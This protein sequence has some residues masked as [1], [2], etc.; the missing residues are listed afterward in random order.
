MC[1]PHSW[2]CRYVQLE[3]KAIHN[4]PEGI[5]S[6]M[7]QI[8]PLKPESTEGQRKG[9]GEGATGEMAWGWGR[10]EAGGRSSVAAQGP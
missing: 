4:D 2:T 9:V 7:G 5:A 6:I 10:W 8:V 3:S 1:R